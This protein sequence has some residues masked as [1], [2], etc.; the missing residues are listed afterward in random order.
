MLLM[1]LHGKFVLNDADY[2]PLNLYGVGIFMAF[3]GRGTYQNNPACEAI[4]LDGP[5]PSG[6][7]WIIDRHEGNWF[8]QTKLEAKDFAH[9]ML[10]IKEFGKSHWFALYKDDWGVDDGTWIEGCTSWVD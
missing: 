8:S 1:A 2:A 3:S 9:R 10:G 7:Y 6:K 5:L 4:A